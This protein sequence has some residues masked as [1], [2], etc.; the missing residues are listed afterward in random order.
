VSRP[1]LVIVPVIIGPALVSDRVWWLKQ[2]QDRF[3][4]FLAAV[5]L[6]E[7]VYAPSYVPQWWVVLPG[8]AH[9]FAGVEEVTSLFDGD[10][11]EQALET[12][13]DLLPQ[14]IGVVWSVLEV[15]NRGRDS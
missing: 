9:P 5:C 11:V 4:E 3:A 7:G 6:N 2:H 15:A 1:V 8:D 14:G 13:D 12:M 10:I